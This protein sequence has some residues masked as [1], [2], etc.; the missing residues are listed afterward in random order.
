MRNRGKVVTVAPAVGI[1]QRMTDPAFAIGPRVHESA[2]IAAPTV[3][4]N[5]APPRSSRKL[6]TVAGTVMTAGFLGVTILGG[7][8]A[9]AQPNPPAPRAVVQTKGNLWPFAR[10]AGCTTWQQNKKWVRPGL[11]QLSVR[12][13]CQGGKAIALD[14]TQTSSPYRYSGSGRIFGQPITFSGV[15]GNGY[16]HR[17]VIVL[18]GR[19]LTKYG[20]RTSI[21]NP[22]SSYNNYDV[23]PATF[24]LGG[25]SY[26]CLRSGQRSGS[27]G[28]TMSTMP[29]GGRHY[30]GRPTKAQR[31]GVPWATCVTMLTVATRHV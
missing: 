29:I 8:S 18:G 4:T 9:A 19:N 10:P 2:Q 7:S 25:R 30:H 11:A 23:T 22:W 21:R 12:A 16:S 6:A 17:P 1:A 13:R 3:S 20:D 14:Y 31:T 27:W 26:Y 24:S 28:V 5:A 15:P